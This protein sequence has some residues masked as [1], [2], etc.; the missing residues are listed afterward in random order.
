M[1]LEGFPVR[2]EYQEASIGVLVGLGFLS[3]S[4]A[5]ILNSTIP[6]VRYSSYSTVAAIP[7]AD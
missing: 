1:V 6:R 2:G 5:Y 4:G 7:K 3:L